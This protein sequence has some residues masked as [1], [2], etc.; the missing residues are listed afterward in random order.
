MS[1][2]EAREMGLA[3]ERITL[4]IGESVHDVSKRSVLIGRG[5]QCDLILT[6]TN[7]SRRH[8]EIRQRGN[9]YLVVD[10]DSTN[11]VEVNGQ[12][13]KTRV[14]QNGD[15]ITIGKTRVRFERQL[16]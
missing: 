1:A 2:G 12:K 10:L 14:L 8:A 11:G 4:T 3:R 13:I 9:D 5:R 15:L 16:C 6:D 7:V